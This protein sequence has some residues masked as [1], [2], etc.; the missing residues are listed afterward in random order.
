M[1]TEPIYTTRSVAMTERA[2]RWSYLGKW[3][4]IAQRKQTVYVRVPVRK[5][6]PELRWTVARSAALTSLADPRQTSWDRSVTDNVRGYFST[7]V[8][9]I[10]HRA[11]AIISLKSWPRSF[12]M[13][14]TSFYTISLLLMIGS[15]RYLCLYLLPSKTTV[16]RA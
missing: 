6:R 16:C 4:Q 7:C 10:S 12:V 8:H 13:N 2:R 15:L 9:I 14:G 3:A 1:S 5:K 11:N